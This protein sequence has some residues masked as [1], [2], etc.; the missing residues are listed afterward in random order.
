MSGVASLFVQCTP[1]FN[2]KLTRNSEGA[3]TKVIIDLC[4]VLLGVGKNEKA[5]HL[6]GTWLFCHDTKRDLLLG[7]GRSMNKRR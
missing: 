5:T 3:A 2:S 7:H 1:L 4:A 6:E